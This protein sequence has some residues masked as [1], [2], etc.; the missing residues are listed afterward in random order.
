VPTRLTADAARRTAV[1]AQGFGEPK[2]V[3][4]V[5]RAHLRR[6]IS[7]IQVLQLDSVSVAVRAH[8]A[9]VFS[10]LGPYDR[11]V[12]DRAAWSHSARAPRLLV[13]Y[14][15]H[16][17]AL[18]AVDD[19]PLLR[20]RMREYTHGR[21]G[22]EIVRNNTKLAEDVIAALSELGPS[23]SGQ[24]E[25]HLESEPRGRKGPWWD[26]SDTKWVAEALFASGVLTT[27]TRV[28]F[29]RHYDLTENVL[30][31]EVVARQ[32]DDDEAVRELVL[33]AATALGVATE[34]DIRDYFRLG[35]KQAKPA[36]A[37]LVAAGE[38]EPVEV[39]GWSAPAYLRVGQTV[40][41][42]DR[43]T[44]LLC[45]FDPLIFFRPRVERIFD[46]RYR[47]EI[48]TPQEKR[49]FGYYVWP[50][51][52]DGRL[53][54]RVDL[55]AERARDALHVVGAFAEP[56]QDGRRVAEALAAELETM[57]S[58]LRL[59]EVTVGERGDLVGALRR[60]LA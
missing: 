56:G 26:R 1:A 17:A 52:L 3:G 16:E 33:R 5:A 11:D 4:A 57:A 51:L 37:E 50:F 49:E 40:S 28:G 59:G 42:R 2:P 14:W 9:P 20:W 7:R 43:G 13:E 34:T 30:P 19:W 32:I 53:V 10:R 58:W 15:A 60:R 27:A 48:Y 22:T 41:R 29:A 12:L 18:M 8:Y 47:I 36:I 55:K 25:A 46:F 44:A 35:A 54:G 31:P 39:D 38:L 21:W 45:P 6:L 23:T 24:I